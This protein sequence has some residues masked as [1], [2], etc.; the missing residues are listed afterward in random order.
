MRQLKNLSG[1]TLT[2]MLVTATNWLEKNGPGLDALNVFPVPD[3][4]TG[5]NML[6]TM[7]AAV[8]EARS[9]GNGSVSR[10]A[11]AV[12][13]GALRGAAGNSGVILSQFWQGIAEEFKGKS[14]VV[15]CELAEAFKRASDMAFRAVSKPVEG[16]ILT[17]MKDIA[18]V[19]LMIAKR[20]ADFVALMGRIVIVAEE[21]VART[22]ELLEVLQ[23]TGVVDAG[24]KGLYTILR[25]ALAYLREEQLPTSGEDAGVQTLEVSLEKLSRAQNSGV[26]PG[27][28]WEHGSLDPSI[29]Y[30][31][32]FEKSH[33]HCIE[34]LI[35]N[36]EIAIEK[37]RTCLEAH[38]NSL[39]IVG[40][41]GAVRVHM[42][43]TEPGTVVC[44]A[45]AFGAVKNVRLFNMDRQCD[46]YLRKYTKGQKADDFAVIAS[47]GGPGIMQAFAGLGAGCVVSPHIEELQAVVHAE[48]A[49]H[50]ILLPNRK[51][52]EELS[53]N[54]QDRPEH[55]THVVPSV[56][57][58]QGIAAMV[59]FNYQESFETNVRR[60]TQALS[61]VV[62]IELYKVNRSEKYG[63]LEAK[64]GQIVS[65]L[66][67]KPAIVG[68]HP[69]PVLL[70]TIE[71]VDTPN[72]EILTV[73][74]G[75]NVSAGEAE[76]LCENVRRIFP[77]TEIEA[78]SGGQQDFDFI[79]SLE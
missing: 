30:S 57:I 28:G 63:A 47:A 34:F 46:T 61:E 71:M 65:F 48:K 32:F 39:V 24:A 29:S 56:T 36:E 5:T 69:F 10:I 26:G 74:S 9:V 54:L 43:S 52:L 14:S 15:T 58:P 45:E 77:N 51:E 50:I 13:R 3:G 18:K 31:S 62:S 27:E 64:T 60:M 41:L 21:S 79:V 7:E 53:Y 22:P 8:R 73:Y 68:D 67:A 6:L 17:V 2:E 75:N 44:Q 70:D 19:A 23:A 35:T 55:S 20:D 4:D 33:G 25:G 49:E 37:V 1:E 78:V 12:A 42:H 76:G 40:G 16:T 66:D 72:I 38:G 59:A 11:D